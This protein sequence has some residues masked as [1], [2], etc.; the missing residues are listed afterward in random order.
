M[1]AAKLETKRISR[2][3]YCDLGQAIADLNPRT[4]AGYVFDVTDTAKIVVGIPIVAGG[5][6]WPPA[7]YKVPDGQLVLGG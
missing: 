3:E 7:I 5:R 6:T 2:E 4:C 1:R